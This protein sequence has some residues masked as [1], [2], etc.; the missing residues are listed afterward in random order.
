[1]LMIQRW[2]LPCLVTRTHPLIMMLAVFR[3]FL[4]RANYTVTRLSR[5]L[6]FIWVPVHKSSIRPR[7]RWLKPSGTFQTY[8]GGAR[9]YQQDLDADLQATPYSDLHFNIGTAKTLF[10]LAGTVTLISAAMLSISQLCIRLRP[11]TH[12]TLAQSPLLS[13]PLNT[14]N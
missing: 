5:L 1:M 12:S 14:S 3:T 9:R 6:R 10:R 7:S 11:I 2:V 4:M 13:F 8:G